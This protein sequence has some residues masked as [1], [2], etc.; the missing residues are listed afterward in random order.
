[1][2]SSSLRAITVSVDMSDLLSITL[3][4]NREHFA[5]VT[6]VTSTKDAETE[7]VAK[8]NNAGVFKTDTFWAGGGEFRKWLALE[9]AL[10]ETGL[11]DS[12]DWLAIMDCDVLW[13]KQIVHDYVL[14]KL[15]GPLRRMWYD[16]PA[17]SAH[18]SLIP[19]GVPPERSWNLFPI[20]PQQ[21][22]WAGFS[23]ILHSDDPVLR[24]RP[25]FDTSWRSCAGG[26][27]FFQ[28]RWTGQDKVRPQWE[29]LH[30]GPDHVNWLG[31]TSPRADGTIP[32]GAKERQEKLRHMMLQR[33]TQT[34]E[35][36][37]EHEKIKDQP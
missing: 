8:A 11:Q 30:L 4:H 22:E 3:P 31:R 2:P 32:E 36:K 18:S 9:T 23:L 1:M 24:Q 14:G 7:A 27:S 16:W 28:M 5:D 26:D 20:H 12:H 37:F 29:V 19:H 17:M 15:Y 34:N 21:H 10:R 35:N 13:P 6:V 25:W 33:R